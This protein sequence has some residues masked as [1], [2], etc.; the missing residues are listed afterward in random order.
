MCGIRGTASLLINR[1]LFNR[2]QYFVCD[3]YKS[4]VLPVNAGVPQGSVLGPLL[5]NILKITFIS[6]LGMK[7]VFFAD[8][9]VFY[10]ES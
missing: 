10:A 1:Y 6:Q 5:F 8:D 4:D 2:D 3:D 7:N 9:A